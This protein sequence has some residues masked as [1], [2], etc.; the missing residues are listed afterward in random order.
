MDFIL[1]AYC[2]LYCGACPNLLNTRV[3]A[4]T[5]RCHGCK[6]GQPAPGDFYRGDPELVEHIGLL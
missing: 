5:E 4:G 2:G 3:G 1:H 6:S